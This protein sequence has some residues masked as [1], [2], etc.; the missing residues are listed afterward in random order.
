V[1]SLQ[2]LGLISNP[3]VIEVNTVDRLQRSWVTSIMTLV[4]PTTTPGEEMCKRDRTTPSAYSTMQDD[5]LAYAAAY[6]VAFARTLT[7]QDDGKTRH[8]IHTMTKQRPWTRGLIAPC[9]IYYTTKA[10][11]SGLLSTHVCAPPL[12]SKGRAH[13]LLRGQGLGAHSLRSLPWAHSNLSIEPSLTNQ[14][15]PSSSHFYTNK[16]RECITLHRQANPQTL[17]IGPVL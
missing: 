12:A 14:S 15:L 1:C 7:R 8:G 5:E 10:H 3:R 16:R 4:V 11:K 6:T 17:A 9:S 2:G 13:S